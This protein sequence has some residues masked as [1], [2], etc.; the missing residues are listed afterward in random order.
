[1][2]YASSFYM[3]VNAQP[4]NQQKYMTELGFCI[5]N[6]KPEAFLVYICFVFLQQLHCYPINTDNKFVILDLI[7]LK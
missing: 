1:M 7:F 2:L 3:A 4:A 6:F 5:Q